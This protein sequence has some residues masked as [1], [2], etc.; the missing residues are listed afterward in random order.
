MKQGLEVNL[1]LWNN[2]LNSDACNSLNYFTIDV[3]T[4]ENG[5]I[6]NE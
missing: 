3:L 6:E 5:E 4:E 2:V 1:L